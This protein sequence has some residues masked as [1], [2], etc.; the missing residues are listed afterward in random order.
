[1]ETVWFASMSTEIINLKLLRHL[2]SA[3]S[4]NEL[5]QKIWGN[6]LADVMSQH[7]HCNTLFKFFPQSDKI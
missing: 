3:Y 1:M 4:L 6:V 7:Q 5:V 2:E